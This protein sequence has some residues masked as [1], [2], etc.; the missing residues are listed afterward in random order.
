MGG[1]EKVK[2]ALKAKETIDI[3]KQG[4][5]LVDNYKIQV[6]NKF[7]TCYLTEPQLENLPILAHKFKTKPIISVVNESVVDSILRVGNCGVLN[8]ASAKNPGGGFL[9]G[10]VAQEEVLCRSSNLYNS[11]SEMKQYYQENRRIK[12]SLYTNNMIY[13]ADILFIRDNLLN[14]VKVPVYANIVTAPAVNAGAYYHKENGDRYTVA[15]VMIN[16]MRYILKLLINKGNTSI[17]LGA[18]GCGVF[19]NDPVDVATIWNNLLKKEGFEYYF[20]NIIFSVYDRQG[21]VY[22]VFKD[23]LS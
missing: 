19:R 11:L 10:M 13:S 16:R 21:N 6:N 18:Y 15:S 20:E 17:I 7:S 23:I 2:N 9:N 5:Y 4:Y 3:F 1:N 12:S 14:L 8:F 22:G